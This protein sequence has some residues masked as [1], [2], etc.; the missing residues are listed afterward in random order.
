MQGVGGVS[1]ARGRRAARGLLWLSVT[2]RGARG[3]GR[4]PAQG[5]PSPAVPA[6]RG[7]AEPV[8]EPPPPLTKKPREASRR[9]R[10]RGAG[11]QRAP[12]Q[13][14]AAVPQRPGDW[15]A[16]APMAWRC[17][18]L[19]PAQPPA[20]RGS[21]SSH[22]ARRRHRRPRGPAPPPPAPRPAGSGPLHTPPPPPAAATAA[23]ASRLERGAG[24]AGNG[25]ESL[26]V[27]LRRCGHVQYS[28]WQY[29]LS[30][31]TPLPTPLTP[32][33]ARRSSQDHVPSWSD[34]HAYL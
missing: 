31:K 24:P 12:S 1:G 23:A 14:E 16:L 8:A 5:A 17:G 21:L 27:L 29:Q 34:M 25:P 18:G 28:A 33:P 4:G 32:Q 10:R 19:R 15:R 11:R 3:G 22:L 30:T 13:S 26:T 7:V 20:G 6:P 9:G 2:E